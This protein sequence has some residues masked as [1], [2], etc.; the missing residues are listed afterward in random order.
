MNPMFYFLLALTTVLAAT[1]DGAEPV[2][3]AAGTPISGGSYY[4]FPIDVQGGGVALS[5]RNGKPCPL[6]I[7]Q[8]SSNAELGIPVKF[9]DWKSNVEFVPESESLNIEMDTAATICGQ[10]TYW[11]VDEGDREIKMLFVAAGPKPEVFHFQI[12]KSGDFFSYKFVVCPNWSQS[13]DDC[14]DVGIFVDENGVR[15]LALGSSLPFS[16]LLMKAIEAEA[17]SKNILLS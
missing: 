3:D 7:V 13:K 2:V 8:D 16:F 5:S 17:S 10:S 1:V 11:S 9:S 6:E 4:I 14:L 12:E 15:R